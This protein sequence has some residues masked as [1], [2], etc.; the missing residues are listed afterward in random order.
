MMVMTT[1]KAAAVTMNTEAGVVMTAAAVA[2]MQWWGMKMTKAAQ[3]AL[4]A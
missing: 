4:S 1:A 2:V 3:A